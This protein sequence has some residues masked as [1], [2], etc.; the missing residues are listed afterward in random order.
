MA[1]IPSN[2]DLHSL[3][4]ILP[5]LVDRGLPGGGE[6]LVS[7]LVADERT[8]AMIALLIWHGFLPMGGNGML[9]PKIH[10]ARCVLPPGNVHIGRKVRRRAKGFRL[11]VDVAWEAVVDGIQKHTYTSHK[12]DCWL[13]DE[14]A[15]TYQA[16]ARL[17]DDQRHGV[18]FH[19][20]ELWHLGTGELVAGEIG[21]SCGAIYSSCTGFALKDEYNGLGSVQMAA[22]ARWLSRSGFVLWDLGMELDYKLELGSKIISRGEW[23]TRVRS[24]RQESVSLVSPDDADADTASLLASSGATAA[25]EAAAAAAE[26]RG[27][28]T[29]AAMTPPKQPKQ[30]KKER[31]E[32][33]ALQKKEAALKETETEPVA[34]SV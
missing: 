25:V 14:L 15:S 7:E 20:V 1:R 16:V 13:S 12:G 17:R 18:A 26:D 8:A 3:N 23:A 29:E 10:K 22:L 11:T 5:Q 4:D 9:L 33:K 2:M 21:Y 34:V 19:S 27:E 31:R 30:T 6:F 24:L 32:Q 28:R